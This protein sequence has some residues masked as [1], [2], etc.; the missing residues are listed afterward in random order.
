MN[1]IKIE[2]QK[3]MRYF[4]CVKCG[5]KKIEFAD[6]GYSTFNVA[7]G[8][9]KDCKNEIKISPCNSDIKKETIVSKWN[10]ANNPKLL[11]EKYQI[12]INELQK[13]IDA[14]PS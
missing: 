1:L 2:K 6:Y 12:Q 14:L 13:L 3:S 7:W 9:C 5:S 4:S 10:D 8:R 11:R